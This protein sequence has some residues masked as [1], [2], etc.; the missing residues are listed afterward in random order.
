MNAQTQF[1]VVEVKS[2][3]F[4]RHLGEYVVRVYIDGKRDPSADYYTDDKADAVESHKA[5]VEHYATTNELATMVA[6]SASWGRQPRA[7]MFRSVVGQEI[8]NPTIGIERIRAIFESL[9]N[10]YRS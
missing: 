1:P 3:K 10:L 7:I 2:P 9:K 5:M 8:A 4:D 6:V